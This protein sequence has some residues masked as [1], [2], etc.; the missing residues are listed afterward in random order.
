MSRLGE[1]IES[2]ERKEVSG[3]E[4]PDENDKQL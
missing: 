3:T 2:E 4:G 1:A